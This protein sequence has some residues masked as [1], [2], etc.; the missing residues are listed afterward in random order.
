MYRKIGIAI[1]GFAVVLSGTTAFLGADSPFNSDVHIE[2]NPVGPERPAELNASSAA[3]FAAR[4]E[5]TRLSNDLL[6]SRG[7]ALDTNDE[8]IAR[9]EATSVTATERDSDRFRVRLRCTGGID[10]A[11]RLRQ[12]DPFEYAVA[13]LVTETE[14]EETDLGDYPFDDRDT[15][16]PRRGS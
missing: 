14:I 4:Y 2:R 3:E 15:L 10:D 11:M 9:C 5:R 6:S 16:R 13:Y 1:V 12:P 7:Y 8:L